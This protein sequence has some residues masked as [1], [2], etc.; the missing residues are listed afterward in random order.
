MN[1]RL[2]DLL[3]GVQDVMNSKGTSNGENLNES[4]DNL[5]V[6]QPWG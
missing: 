5:Y 4:L 3:L 6:D 1:E 2:D